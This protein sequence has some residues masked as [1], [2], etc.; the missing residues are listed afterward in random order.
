MTSEGSVSIIARSKQLYEQRLRSEL[1]ATHKHEFVA[2]EPDSGDY[3]V[4]STFDSVAVLAKS[5]HPNKLMHILRI[6]DPAAFTIGA[7]NR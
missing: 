4:A 1:E 5:K 2:I 3:F 7:I 6:G